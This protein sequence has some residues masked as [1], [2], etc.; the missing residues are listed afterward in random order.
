[1]ATQEKNVV[2][3]ERLFVDR[4]TGTSRLETPG[5]GG[6]IAATF[7]QA[8]GS[9]AQ[10]K[11]PPPAAEALQTIGGSFKNDPDAPMEVE[12]D[13]LDVLETAK[14]AV[15]KGDVRARQGEMLLL[16]S[17]L[18]AFFSGTTGLGLATA[19][20][21]TGAKAKGQD[22]GQVVRLE[23]KDKVLLTSKDGQT[24]SAKK[25]TFDVKA[26][27]ALLVGD[28]VVTKPGNDPR[29]PQKQRI[30]VLEAPRLKIDLTTGV[31]WMEADPTRTVG[32]PAGR[33]EGA[34]HIVEPSH[35]VV[36]RHDQ[37]RG[38]AVCARKG[39][40]AH[41]SQPGQGQGIG[42]PEEEGARG[43]CALTGQASACRSPAQWS[44]TRR[45]GRVAS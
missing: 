7:H 30:T 36:G 32:P 40:R 19:A 9:Q 29:D 5:G 38:P 3:G 16:A 24:A 25:A 1:M 33:D 13:T 27:T 14:K 21:D 43:R 2:K 4:K 26:N 44:A 28:V 35:N 22:K 18:T 39:V 12:A 20:D 10:R 37:G 23:A 45:C 15:F 34:G 8:A 41:L 11:K 6:R 17:E 42:R 31:Y